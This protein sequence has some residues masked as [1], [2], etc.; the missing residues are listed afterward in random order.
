[1]QVIEFESNAMTVGHLG[2]RVSLIA[3]PVVSVKK[4]CLLLE[5]LTHCI[6]QCL[7]NICCLGVVLCAM[8]LFVVV[9]SFTER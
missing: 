6:C 5:E 3:Y 2:L 7:Q 1:M 8:L 4:V 9:I